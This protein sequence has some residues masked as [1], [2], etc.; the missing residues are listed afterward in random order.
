MTTKTL[1]LVP[2]QTTRKAIAQAQRSKIVVIRV[3]VERKVA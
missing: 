1:H 2:R 3:R